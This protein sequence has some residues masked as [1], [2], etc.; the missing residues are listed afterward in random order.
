MR[1]SAF[2][3]INSRFGY[4]TE[5]NI[6]GLD[7]QKIVDAVGQ[8]IESVIVVYFANGSLKVKHTDGTEKL[9]VPSVGSQE[10]SNAMAIN[11]YR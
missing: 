6:G 10:I 3:G 11:K 1:Y 5:L 2:N 8:S 7:L 4:R 9:S